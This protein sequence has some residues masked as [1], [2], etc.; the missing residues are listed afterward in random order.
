MYIWQVILLCYLVRVVILCVRT[1][2][3]RLNTRRNKFV[4]KEMINWCNYKLH[5][6]WNVCKLEYRV[7]QSFS[8]LNIPL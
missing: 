8:I 6:K 5:H 7:T 1:M 3:G 2:N 4:R